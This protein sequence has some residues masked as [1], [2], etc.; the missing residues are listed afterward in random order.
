M[1]KNRGEKRDEVLINEGS[2]TLCGRC[3]EVCHTDA[4]TYENRLKRL[5]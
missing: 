4:L 5:I 2:C 1:A 3:V